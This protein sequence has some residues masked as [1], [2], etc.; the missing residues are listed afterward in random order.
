MDG[1]RGKSDVQ[2]RD[3]AKAAPQPE[4]TSHVASTTRN[5]RRNVRPSL[6][7]CIVL[8]SFLFVFFQSSSYKLQYT[9]LD[10]CTGTSISLLVTKLRTP[11]AEEVGSDSHD[12]LNC[13]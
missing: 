5:R 12:G 9:V 4:S 7:L 6:Q 13:Q 1:W 10:P 3:T 8:V 11:F 2:D